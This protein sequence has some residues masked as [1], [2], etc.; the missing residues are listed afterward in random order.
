MNAMLKHLVAGFSPLYFGGG[1]SPA[2]APVPVNPV[3]DSA[4]KEQRLSVERA[5]IVDSKSRGRQSTV[6]AG[7]AIAAEEQYGVGLLKSKQR[8]GSASSEMM[9]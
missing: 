7:G 5:A 2:P 1:K 9:G 3:D 6:A 8:R 4:A